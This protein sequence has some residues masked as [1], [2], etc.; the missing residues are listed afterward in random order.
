MMHN[1]A[2]V[3]PRAHRKPSGLGEYPQSSRTSRDR[4]TSG[5]ESG[6]EFRVRVAKATIDIQHHV[7]VIEALIGKR[8]QQP[9]CV[10]LASADLARNQPEKVDPNASYF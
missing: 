6:N 2:M 7:D 10:F 3:E 1:L 4:C 9:D 5:R 8:G